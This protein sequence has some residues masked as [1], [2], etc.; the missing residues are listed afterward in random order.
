MIFLRTQCGR[1]FSSS[2]RPNDLDV[3]AK[4]A[5]SPSW[6]RS[7]GHPTVFSIA[8]DDGSSQPIAALDV[9]VVIDLAEG[10]RPTSERLTA[11]W[12]RSAV[13]LAITDQVLLEVD[14]QSD[15]VL[16]SRHRRFASSLPRLHADA[17]RWKPLLYEMR[18]K[19]ANPTKYDDDLHHAAKAA[20]GGA[21]WLVTRD[22]EFART[23]AKTI[24]EVA[25]LEVVS[26]GEFLVAADALI[27]H[28]TY[29]PTDLHGSSVQLRSV[30]PGEFEAVAQAFVNHNL[31]CWRRGAL[32]MAGQDLDKERQLALGPF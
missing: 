16:R 6:F 3:A 17:S 23:C 5:G 11:D 21:R 13:R 4:G 14:D 28:D 10:D 1:S 18:A 20:A 2:Q 29:R 15:E 31:F 8:N 25:D 26:P 9:N 24:K 27:R 19:L 22:G 12:T 32:H 7:F 30:R